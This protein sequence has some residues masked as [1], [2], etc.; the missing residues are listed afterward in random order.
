MWGKLEFGENFKGWTLEPHTVQGRGVGKGLVVLAFKAVESRGSGQSPHG[1]AIPSALWPGGPAPLEGVP[2][3]GRIALPVEPVTNGEALP[4]VCIRRT[5][6]LGRVA[7]GTLHLGNCDIVG[8]GSV[9]VLTLLGGKCRGSFPAPGLDLLTVGTG[10]TQ[11]C[12]SLGM[13]AR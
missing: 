3:A 13:A 12:L 2:Q 10:M 1:Q 4:G 8:Q 6:L 11:F 5:W 7:V 9:C